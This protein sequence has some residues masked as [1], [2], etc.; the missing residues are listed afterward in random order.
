MTNAEDLKRAEQQAKAQLDTIKAMVKRLEHCQDCT[1]DDCELTD[2]EVYEGINLYWK[3]G[4]E[5]DEDQRI[6]YHDEDEARQ[7]IS[8]DPL[9]VQVRSGWANSLEEFEAEEYEILLCTGGPACRIIGELD[10]SEPDSAR[11]QYQDWFT[12]WTEY[13]TTGED[14]EALLTYARQFYFGS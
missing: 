9:S 11:L 6:Q 5:A 1:G 2:A 3:E 10:R 4:D 13:I 12:P 14:H 8:E 7:A